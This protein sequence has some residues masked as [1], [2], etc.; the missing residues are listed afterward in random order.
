MFLFFDRIYTGAPN[1]TGSFRNDGA[2]L[3]NGFADGAFIV[4]D[5]NQRYC[6]QNTNAEYRN[7]FW[8][9]DVSVLSSQYQNGLSEIRVKSTITEGYIKLF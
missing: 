8:R 5:Y 7:K 9:L 6:N 1:I 2:I 3:Y 4:S